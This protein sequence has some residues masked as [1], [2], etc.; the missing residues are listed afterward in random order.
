MEA[1]AEHVTGE[2]VEDGENGGAPVEAEVVEGH[3]AELVPMNGAAMVAVAVKLGARMEP[4]GLTISDPDIS[5]EGW[6]QIGGAIG[7]ATDACHW[8]IGDWFLFGE[9]AFGEDAAH[10]IPD[11]SER[12]S[13]L[14]GVTRLEQGRLQNIV[15]VA[16]RVS[17]PVRREELSFSHHEA[18][19]SCAA[20]EQKKWLEKAVKKSW[21]KAQLA[22]AIRDAKGTKEPEPADESKLTAAQRIEQAANVV[23]DTSQRTAHG[24]WETPD[25]SMAQLIAALG[26]E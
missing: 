20:P 14:R 12:Y 15:S 17:R 3:G 16:H 5:F 1:V 13:Y 2:V 11:K 7:F 22:E 24:T 18:V 6:Q 25:E 23:A 8:W 19:A 21:S 9:A 10:A 4:T 26:R